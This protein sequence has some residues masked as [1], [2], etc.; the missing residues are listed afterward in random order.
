MQQFS[1]GLGWDDPGGYLRQDWPHERS[2]RG[3]H[4]ADEVF[5]FLLWHCSAALH[6]GKSSTGFEPMVSGLPCRGL[7]LTRSHG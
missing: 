5:W 6:G 3:S 7:R 2:R 4:G 1:G